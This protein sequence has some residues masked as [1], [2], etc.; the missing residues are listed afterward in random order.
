MGSAKK[1]KKEDE[2]EGKGPYSADEIAKV[3][4]KP[5][6]V[7]KQ[8]RKFGLYD[9]P[10]LDQEKFYEAPEQKDSLPDEP[11][12]GKEKFYQDSLDNEDESD[13]KS[14]YYY[15]KKKRK[16]SKYSDEDSWDGL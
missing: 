7:K 4:K 15:K 8:K 9:E 13:L 1:K 5:P 2:K 16:K 3:T 11:W 12:L 10:W 14:E 6:T